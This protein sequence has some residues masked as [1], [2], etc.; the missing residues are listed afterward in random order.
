MCKRRLGFIAS[1]TSATVLAFIFSTLSFVLQAANLSGVVKD[2][3]DN[4]IEGANV[5][6]F[7][8]LGSSSFIQVGDTI[9]VGA[10]GAYAWSVSPESYVLRA[11]FN[12]SEVSL[13]GTP[14]TTTIQSE[15]FEVTT[16][17]VRDTQFDFVVLSGKVVDSNDTPIANVDIQTS[18]SWLGPEQGAKLEL[19][20]QSLGHTAGSTLT[21][22]NGNY[23][24][25]L[26]STDTCIASGF[27]P[28]STDCLYDLT[29]T[30]P[31]ASGFSTTVRSNFAINSAQ[32][33]DQALTLVD[34][35]NPKIIAG[36]YVKNITDQSAVIEWQTDEAVSS[37]T[38][39]VGGDLFT[40]AQLQTQHSVVVTG[41]DPATAYNVELNTA[42]A[43]NNNSTTANFAFTTTNSNADSLAP[44]FIQPLSITAIA[45]TQMTMAF[46]ANEPVNGK[47]VVD[48]TDYLLNDF[49]NCHELTINDLNPNQSYAVSAEISD[50]ASNGP[51]TSLVTNV[52]TLAAAD[53][54]PPIITTSPTITDISDTT[55]V[56]RWTTNE[57]ASSGISFN[58]GTNYR[59][60]NDTA[61]VTEHSVQV[62]G[63]A[64]NTTYYLTV[65]SKDASGNSTTQ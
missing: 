55:A 42:D 49:S 32:N 8:A 35:L 23:E 1:R 58:D 57:P 37:S 14:N 34:Q 3:L 7:Q 5:K 31:V 30:P 20:Q 25:L 24:M 33:L 4:P 2:H 26:F 11:Y 51:T 53:L 13:A 59:V 56:V 29:Y 6:L 63:L 22:A 12:A 27:Y 50:I 64:T 10:D 46:C 19:S 44:Q 61:L 28:D 47:F 65:A 54:S 39:I 41:L 9:K 21:D 52:K 18:T 43:Q 38:Q 15:D 60:Q 17:T 48:N 16:D 45:E 62:T 40:N 36:P